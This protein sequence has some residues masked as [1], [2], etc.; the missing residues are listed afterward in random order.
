[1]N[2]LVDGAPTH[3]RAAHAGFRVTRY[4]AARPWI[5]APRPAHSFAGDFASAASPA[6]SRALHAQ[7]A[8]ALVDGS[9][10]S[11]HVRSRP[12][13]HRLASLRC[14][15]APR[16]SASSGARRARSSGKLGLAMAP[17]VAPAPKGR[18]HGETRAPSRATA[19]SPAGQCTFA[20]CAHFR[21]PACRHPA[22]ARS[23]NALASAGPDGRAYDP[24]IAAV[25]RPRRQAHRAGQRPPAHRG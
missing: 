10:V 25:L 12:P 13:S 20:N 14:F 7:P 8:A 23:P 16:P 19:R 5:A 22:T 4:H 24:L 18:R 6:S 17:R 9:P 1:M 21:L 15:R 11:E 3:R 2:D